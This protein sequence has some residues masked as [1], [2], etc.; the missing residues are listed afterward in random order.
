MT[1]SKVIA[2]T[3]SKKN[4]IIKK[5]LGYI[6]FS[7]MITIIFAPAVRAELSCTFKV[8]MNIYNERSP[9]PRILTRLSPESRIDFSY[10]GTKL[11]G[12]G[13]HRIV[14]FS[15][16]ELLDRGDIQPRRRIVQ[17]R[18]VPMYIYLR[19]SDFNGY[20]CVVPATTNF[21]PPQKR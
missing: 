10:T 21:D 16:R 14:S 20:A 6:L 7:S 11:L 17:G 5:L 9:R 1:T 18:A 13:W 4:P 8:T 3:Y 19:S 12:Q 15:R 2:E